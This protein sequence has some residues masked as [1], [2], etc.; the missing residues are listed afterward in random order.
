MGPGK[1]LSA[2]STIVNFAL[3]SPESC[4]F[5]AE[6]IFVASCLV[7]QEKSQVPLPLLEAWLEE[8]CQASKEKAFHLS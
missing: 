3:S 8:F 6:E 1:Y 2:V 5:S 4:D 7:T